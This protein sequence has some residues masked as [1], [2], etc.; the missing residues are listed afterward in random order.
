MERAYKVWLEVSKAAVRKNV[1]AFRTLLDKKT[2]LYAVVKSNAYGH[3]LMQFSVI[4]DKA[5]VDG[6]CVDSVVEGAKLRTHGIEKPILVLGYTL[7]ALYAV[8]AEHSITVTISNQDALTAWSKASTKPQFH[9]KIDT[10][11]HRQ[12]FQQL[13]IEGLLK[14]I[15]NSELGTRNYLKGV[16]THFAMAKNGEDKTFTENQL[17]VFKDIY[18]LFEK[19]G[20]DS[21]ICHASA[22]GG[23]LLGKEFHMDMVRVGIG[24]YG[25]WPSAELEGQLGKKITLTQALSLHS[26]ISELKEIKKGEVVGYDCT[27]RVARDTRLAII[28]IGYWHGIPRAASSIG[29]VRIGVHTARIVGRVSMDMVVVDVTDIPCKIGVEVYIL[30]LELA[31]SISASPYEVITR[32]NPLIHKVLV[33]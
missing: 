27:E 23:T 4:A 5:G 30:P 26:V 25:I 16:Y 19:A 10:G 9:L 18:V 11:M 8:A 22:T 20:F 17:S 2:Q 12:G 24:L 21:L 13:E 15:R 14:K 28:P 32:I 7:P 3:G 6:F 31:R 29:S 1:R 33:R